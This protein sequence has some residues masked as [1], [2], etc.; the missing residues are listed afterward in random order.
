MNEQFLTWQAK[1]PTRAGLYIRTDGFGKVQLLHV[2]VES[3]LDGSRRVY[4]TD[5]TPG[6]V[7]GPLAK[8][9]RETIDVLPDDDDK[10]TARFLGPIALPA[11]PTEQALAKDEYALPSEPGIYVLSRNY[12]HGWIHQFIAVSVH[13]YTLDGTTFSRELFAIDLPSLEQ[14]ELK[15]E[16]RGAIITLALPDHRRLNLQMLQPAC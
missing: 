8:P 4:L 5:V 9:F 10:T 7:R 6:Y 15:Q 16:D 11:L 1:A 12:G 3:F 2:S 13:G 14:R